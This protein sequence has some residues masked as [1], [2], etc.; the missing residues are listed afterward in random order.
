MIKKNELKRMNEKRNSL[1][2]SSITKRM[3]KF[4]NILDADSSSEEG[5][6]P[7]AFDIKN[8]GLDGEI[9]LSTTEQP[10]I[11]LTITDSSNNNL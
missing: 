10:H 5:N 2:I 6:S 11:E 9:T 7:K 3:T 1:S 8:M 4:A